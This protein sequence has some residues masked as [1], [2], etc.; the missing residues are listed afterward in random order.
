[1]TLR[2]FHDPDSE[3]GCSGCPLFGDEF[4]TC[5]ALASDEHPD[6]RPIEP[7]EPGPDSFMEVAP[8]WCPLREGD[9]VV[10]RKEDR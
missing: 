5:Q 8:L 3:D 10:A 1:M 7:H 4:F 6:G 9:V 2:L